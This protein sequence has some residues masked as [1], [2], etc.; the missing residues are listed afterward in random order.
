M[1]ASS[2]RDDHP[3]SR[4]GLPATGPGS[5]APWR[6]RIAALLLDWALS[7][8]L[9]ILIFTP[10][11]LTATD[12]RRW[13]VLAL[14]FV[15]TAALSVITGASAGQLACRI[16]VARLDRQ[17]LGPLRGIA[18]AL[19]VSLALPAMI[20]GPDRRGLH[21]LVVGTVVLSRR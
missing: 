6:A 1:P 8:L 12:W 18:R 2:T 11:V 20:I 10:E 3:G 13:M 7:M 15:Q 16:T 19:L 17:R 5:L 14:F 9:A 21:D 4:L